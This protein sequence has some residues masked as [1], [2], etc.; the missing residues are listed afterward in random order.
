MP[1]IKH[2]DINVKVGRKIRLARISRGL[3]LAKLA[4]EM[5]VSWQQVSKYEL[6]INGLRVSTLKRMS[7]AL[8]T[9]MS[10][11]ISDK[12]QSKAQKEKDI[13]LSI[14]FHKNFNKLSVKNRIMINKLIISLQ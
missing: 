14:E 5:D 6:G 13:R 3:S 10:Y 2:K 4:K 8:N 9:P 11:F 1:R 7:E 12:R